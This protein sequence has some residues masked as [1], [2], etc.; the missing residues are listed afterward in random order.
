MGSHF[1]GLSSFFGALETP[2]RYGEIDGR[3]GHRARRNISFALNIM[4]RNGRRDPGTVTVGHWCL[5]FF[6]G[7]LHPMETKWPWKK[8]ELEASKLAVEIG[9]TLFSDKTR[10]KK[11]DLQH[12]VGKH[13]RGH[14]FC[15][16]LVLISWFCKRQFHSILHWKCFC[17]VPVVGLVLSHWLV[18][19]QREKGMIS[20]W[21][22]GVLYFRTNPN[23][24]R[25]DGPSLKMAIWAVCICIP[26][27]YPIFLSQPLPIIA[28]DIPGLIELHWITIWVEEPLL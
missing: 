14:W 3:W 17:Q 10:Q 1:V 9:S 13:F 8:V 2:R 28:G 23:D 18:P 27:G 15:L 25:L 19:F 5:A 24:A 22:L 7:C 20:Q 6:L 11:S 26:L 12:H 4:R 21:I 16:D